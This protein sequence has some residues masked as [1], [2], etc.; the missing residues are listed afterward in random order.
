MSHITVVHACE[1]NLKNITLDIPRGKLT[2]FTGLSGSGKSTLLMDVLYMECQRQYLEAMA[3][4]GIAKPKVERILNVSPA[5]IISQTDAN[6][7][8]RST[9]GTLTDIYTGLRMIYEKLGVRRCPSCG[10]IISAADCIEETQKTD[11]NFLVHMY[12]CEC[13]YK[14]RKL[15][16]T[17]FSFNTREGACKTCEGLGRILEV[18]QDA[19]VHENL[20]LEEGAVDFWE[21][22]YKDYQIEALRAAYCYYRIPIPENKPV[23]QYDDLQKAILYEGVECGQVKKA[24]P[25][26][27]IPKTVANGRFEGI[28]P[29][30]RRRFANQNGEAGYLQKYFKLSEC[31]DCHG[32]RLCETSRKITVNQV[33]L[34][35][36]AGLS[37]HE[38]AGW[39]KELKMVLREKEQ[40]M[41]KDYLL[42]IE[43]KV[44]RFLNVGLGYLTLDRQIITLSGG[45]LQ[46]IRLA[47][48]LDSD[49][50]G[51]IYIL[52]EPTVG[53]HP[54]DTGGL[55]TIL[56]RLRDLGNTVLV[57]EHDP[58]VMKAADHIVDMGPGS[59]R[60]GGNIIGYGTLDEIRKQPLS[61]TGQY[62]NQ[63]HPGKSTFREGNG[64]FVKIRNACKFNLKHLDVDIPLG[65][66]VTITGPSGSG[67]STLICEI[68]ALGNSG[69]KENRV[70]G[71]ENVDEIIQVGQT[72]IN[73]SKRSNIATYTEIYTEIRAIFAKLEEAKEQGLTARDFSFNTPG[74]R[75]ENCEGMGVV[76]N[77]LLFFENNEV[78]CPV[79]RGKRF[80][81]YVL[82]VKL[83]GLSITDI[84]KLSVEEA[85]PVFEK[86]PK[87]LRTLN[88]LKDVG[89][90]Y[91]EIGQTLTT[92]SGGEGQRLKLAKELIGNTAGRGLYLL[93]EPTRGLHPLDIENFLKLL[94]RLAD[95]GNSVIVIEHNQQ[96]IQNSDWIIDLGPDGGEQG[97]RLIYTGPPA[98]L[99]AF[100]K[101]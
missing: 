18:D 38:L 86:H 3:Y 35:Q 39:I 24:F 20:T 71:C 6:K 37:M 77:N 30:L 94:N 84:L 14:M 74:G 31:P 101:G 33:R 56:K 83:N 29:T 49:L 11:D 64:S 68:L 10:K 70:E 25:G 7:N 58:D 16:R 78:V 76:S 12:C 21:K 62:L 90:G 73:R 69:G 55:I 48:V 66:L 97:G 15:T 57:I 46:R 95:T 100:K 32:E 28:F 92:L 43:T 45:E 85:A 82:S 23:R 51:I 54:K 75:C 41:V 34:P 53:L 99:P 5:I 98:G 60:F 42:D 40:G 9:V 44:H 87:I 63:P 47:A 4:Q 72:S 36:L 19:A 50:T 65:C 79:C 80:Q 17:D 2:V 27:G 22:K 89:L 93:D 61:V 59:G 26:R 13:N 81:D 1:G 88:L 8:P 91:L 67:K 96:I 52:D